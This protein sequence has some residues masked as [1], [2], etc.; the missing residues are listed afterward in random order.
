[1]GPIHSRFTKYANKSKLNQG[2]NSETL[3]YLAK[4]T[5]ESKSTIPTSKRS[6]YALPTATFSLSPA[7]PVNKDD[8]K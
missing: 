8:K 5:K 3:T 4:K 7:S 1:M 2:R 6:V